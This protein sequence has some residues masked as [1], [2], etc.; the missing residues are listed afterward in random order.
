VAGWFRIVPGDLAMR[1]LKWLAIGAGMVVVLLLDA[2]QLGLFQGTPP[3]DLGVR[4]G[5]LKGPADTANSVSSQARLWP[6]H[7]QRDYADIAPLS[8]RGDGAETIARLQALVLSEQGASIVE[9]RPD[10][11]RAQ[12]TTRLMKFV[13]DVEFWFDPATGAIQVRSASRVGRKDF[14]VNRQRVERLRARLAE[15]S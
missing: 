15:A 14:G 6:D 4:D 10:Y 13:D 8:L 3:G 2:G 11:L 1:F 7:P 9:S 12:F 5:R